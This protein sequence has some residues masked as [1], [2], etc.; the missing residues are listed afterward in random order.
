MK[1]TFFSE[2]IVAVRGGPRLFFAPLVAVVNIV[3][4]SASRL[5]VKE[6]SKKRRATPASPEG[7]H[8]H[9]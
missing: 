8:G 9:K 1:S 4:A 6:E 7:R 5:V 3:R 2:F